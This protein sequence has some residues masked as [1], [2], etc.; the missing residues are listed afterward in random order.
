MYTIRYL[1]SLGI[2]IIAGAMLYTAIIMFGI[3]KLYP[4]G[5]TPY[6]VTS[7]ILFVTISVA[8]LKFYIPRLR[9]TWRL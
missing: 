3:T 9:N 2:T 5:E 6:W 4:L 8:G 7:G 1:V